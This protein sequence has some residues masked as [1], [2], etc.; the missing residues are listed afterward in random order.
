MIRTTCPYCGVGCGLKITPDGKGGAEVVGRSR[1][2]GQSRAHLLQGRR[3]RRDAVARRPAAPSRGRRPPRV[4]GRAPS[5]PWRDG[6]REIVARHGPDA[7][8][9]YV[10][11]PAPDRGLLRRQQAHQR[12]LGHRQHRHQFA[13]LHGLVGGRPQARLR[14]RHR[15]GPLRGFRAGRPRRAGR[16]QS[17]L[18]PSRAVPAPGGG[19]AGAAGHAHRRRRS[20][21]HR[22]LR[23]R[24]PAS[25][26]AARQ[27]RRPVQRAAGRAAAPR[28]DGPPLRR[29]AHGRHGRRADRGARQRRWPV[30]PARR[31]TWRPS[32]T[33]SPGPRRPSRS[34]PRA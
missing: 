25:G 6:F 8:A 14:Q 10:S 17:R 1:S 24:R 27:R 7:V 3:A 2:S 12:L 19:Q 5:T 22:D 21:P 23:Y 29:Q 15:A 34:I 30:R 4:V 9:F 20:A 13:A 31:P 26:A 33:G 11:G 18:V 32:S 16:Q 28:R